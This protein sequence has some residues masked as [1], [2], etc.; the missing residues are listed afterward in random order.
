M[1]I[2]LV[3]GAGFIGSNLASKL[4]Q[5]GDS[6]TVFD[7]FSTGTKKNLDSM[8]VEV[9]EADLLSTREVKLFFDSKDFDFCYHLAALGS[10]PRSIADPSSSFNANVVGTFNLLE[11]IRIKR[12]PLIYT[13][14]SSV[15]GSNS[16][17]PKEEMDWQL[18]ISPYGGFKAANEDILKSYSKAY[19]L[20]IIIFRLFNVYGPHQNPNGAYAAVIPRWISAALHGNPIKVHGDGEQKRD[21]TY[22]SDVTEVLKRASEIEIDIGSPINLAFGRPISLNE[23]V[24]ILRQNFQELKVEYC[25]NR[26]GDI[27]NSE[28][29]PEKLLEV[30]GPF[31]PKDITEGI[32]ETIEWNKRIL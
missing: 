17:L 12:I 15:Y 24:K 16:K 9:V 13:S 14:S 27:R 8:N 21:F 18:P 6:V 29:S 23:V 28:S 25:E 10:V 31:A 22:V 11:Q 30:I 5:R 26:Q 2:A 1:Q 32:A 20:K 4:L 3:G 7:N 19:N